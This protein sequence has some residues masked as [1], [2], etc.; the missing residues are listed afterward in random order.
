MTEQ[1]R[2]GGQQRTK[3]IDTS[4][5]KGRNDSDES[6]MTE[7]N[8]SEGVAHEPVIDRGVRLFK[9]HLLLFHQLG[10]NLIRIYSNRRRKA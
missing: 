4:G 1:K 6:V 7:R 2:P 3:L 10:L 5:K 8:V 9:F